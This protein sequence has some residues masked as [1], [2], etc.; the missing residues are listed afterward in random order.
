[1]LNLSHQ[2][3]LKRIP[4]QLEGWARSLGPRGSLVQRRLPREEAQGPEVLG[5]T[6]GPRQPGNPG[7]FHSSAK[8]TP[9]T[10]AALVV[11]HWP[12]A[13][14]QA[15][16]KLACTHAPEEARRAKPSPKVQEC[17]LI[18]LPSSISGSIRPVNQLCLWGPAPNTRLRAKCRGLSK[19]RMDAGG[20]RLPLGEG[21]ATSCHRVSCCWST[22]Q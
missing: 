7:T 3:G 19:V 8:R 18:V 16:E 20:R 11:Q 22:S 15:R 14:L 21:R 5:G 4:Q 12:Q 13:C 1:M 2:D 9:W 6:A 17:D 10:Q